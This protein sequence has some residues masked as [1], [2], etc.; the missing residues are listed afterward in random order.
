[1]VSGIRLDSVL[2]QEVQV[3]EKRKG[4]SMMLLNVAIVVCNLNGVQSSGAERCIMCFQSLA[5]WRCCQY[6][7]FLP[8]GCQFEIGNTHF[9]SPVACF[10]PFLQ[11]DTSD[12]GGYLKNYIVPVACN[13]ICINL[14]S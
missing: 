13:I 3:G 12:L 7:G 6:A 11:S 2:R 10:P 5:L 14:N 1:M 8:N 4:C 9:C